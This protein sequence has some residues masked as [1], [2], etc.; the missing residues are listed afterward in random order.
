MEPTGILQMGV[1]H[2]PRVQASKGQEMLARKK[3][4]RCD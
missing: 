1:V 3:E 4:F 2:Q